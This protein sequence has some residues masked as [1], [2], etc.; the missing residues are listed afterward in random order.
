MTV[1]EAALFL[2]RRRDSRGR[3]SVDYSAKRIAAQAIVDKALADQDIA[4]TVVVV[5]V[6]TTPDPLVTEAL[7]S[8][9]NPNPAVAW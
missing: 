4:A 7:A 9:P 5:P 3:P 6:D 1:L 8:L 2:L